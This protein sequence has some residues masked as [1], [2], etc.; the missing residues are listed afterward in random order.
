MEAAPG[1]PRRLRRPFP[2]RWQGRCVPLPEVLFTAARDCDLEPW[3][4]ALVVPLVCP[5]AGSAV[6]V[7]GRRSACLSFARRD[8]PVE[9]PRG[10]LT[11]SGWLTTVAGGDLTASGWVTTVTGGASLESRGV[12][13]LVQR[14]ESRGDCRAMGSHWLLDD[15]DTRPELLGQLTN[16][17]R[18]LY[19]QSALEACAE[20]VPP[21]PVIPDPSARDARWKR[22]ERRARRRLIGLHLNQRLLEM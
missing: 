9:W 1:I 6:T 19:L 12:D 2:A 20:R 21:L 18:R 10:E 8:E 11:A 15:P 7:V 17:L 16:Q 3:V 4:W 22:V 14:G 5:P 13:F